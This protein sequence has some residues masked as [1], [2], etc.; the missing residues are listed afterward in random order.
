MWQ[1]ISFRQEI[2][3]AYFSNGAEGDYYEE[4]Y[5]QRCKHSGEIGEACPILLLHS[6]WN[7]E[8]CNGDKLDATPGVKAKYTALNALWPR[9]GAHNGR[10]AMFIRISEKD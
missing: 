3:M 9:D 4:K 7:Y 8:A 1:G 10:C 5:C 2:K 6:K